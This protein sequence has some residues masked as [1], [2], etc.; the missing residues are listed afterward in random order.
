MNA[1]F[2]QQNKS[3]EPTLL[4]GMAIRVNSMIQR[5]QM[6]GIF[7][8]SFN[9]LRDL[10]AVFGWDRTISPD[11]IWQMYSRGG[12]A[13]RVI[14]AFPE[15]IWGRPP[16]LYIKGNPTWNSDWDVFV[17]N[18][19]LWDLC[20]RL[21]IM[22]GLGRYACLLIGTDKGNLDSSV[23][24]GAKITYMEPFAEKDL[25]IL[26][27]ETNK[28]SPRFGKPLFYQVYPAKTNVD[29]PVTIL[30]APQRV[31]FK[32]H[33]SRMVHVAQNAL[34]FEDFGE[35]M[36]IPIWN[37]L[38]D[39]QKVVGSSSES[40]W[41]TAFPG[42][43]ANVDKDMDLDPEDEANL[44]A[45]LDE[46]SHSFRR[47]IRTR[48]VDVN[49]IGKGI[50]D[51]RASFEVL[52]TLISGTTGIP[53]RILLGSE[54]GQLAS[55]Q[56]KG[57]WAERIEER[58]ANFCTPRIIKKVVKH[59][60]DTG[61]METDLTTMQILWPEAYRMSPLERGQQSA[62]IART[63]ANIQKGLQPIEITP[64]KPAVPPSVGPN[65][66]TIPGTPEVPGTTAEPLLTRDEARKLLG[67]ATD[68]NLVNEVPE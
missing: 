29:R 65:G 52:L 40:Y 13:K 68:Q 58:R 31:P 56:D 28:A 38:T 50:A 45:E 8:T 23:P 55:T 48:G 64:A 4:Q 7:G 26:S 53:K 21:D 33:W 59:L 44:S 51:A 17:E 2:L 12:I 18:H 46:Y 9:G 24:K 37:Y 61:I 42:L 30:D 57:N 22:S 14:T 63:L 41:L 16:Q 66:E 27:Y 43:H 6:A 15:A 3:K 20:K 36:Y 11:H 35:A 60:N 32:V 39:L 10:Y 49:A 34:E 47:F 1:P 5:M 54:A 62:Q 67:L 19:Q 25:K